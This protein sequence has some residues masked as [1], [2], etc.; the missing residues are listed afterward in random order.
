MLNGFRL[1]EIGYYQCHFFNLKIKS[2]FFNDSY[3]LLRFK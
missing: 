1:K 2:F 3:G